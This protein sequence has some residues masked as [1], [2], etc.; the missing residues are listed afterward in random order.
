MLKT[1]RFNV[2]L[3]TC[4]QRMKFGMIACLITSLMLGSCACLANAREIAGLW[5]QAPMDWAYQGQTDLAAAGFDPVAKVALI[6]GHFWQQ[7][8]FEINTGGRYV[9]DFKNTSVIG[10]FRHIILDARMHPVAELQGGIESDEPNPFFLRHG[11]EIDFPAGHYRL[12][13]ELKSPFFLAYPQPYLDTLAH[14]RQAIKPWNALTL[15]CL[16]LF[17]GLLVYYLT[18]AIVRRRMSDAMYSIFILGNLLFNG[19]ALLV[20]PE[21]FGMHW[22]YLVSFPILFSNAAYVLF[23]MSLLKIRRDAY[24]RLHGA[25]VGLLVLMGSL[26]GLA[27]IRPHW[28]LEIDRYGVGLFLIYGLIIGILRSWQGSVTA[29]LY[30][31]AIVTFF[32]LGITTISAQSLSSYTLYIEHMGLFSVSVEIMLLALVITHQ[33][34]QLYHQKERAIERMEQSNRAARIDAM[35]GLPNRVALSEALDRMPSHGS[36]TFVDIDGLK[37][38]NDHFGHR[39]GDE[40]LCAFAKHLNERLGPR[41]RAHRLGGDEFAITCEQGDMSWVEGRLMQAVADMRSDGFEFADASAGSAYVHEAQDK[42]KLQHLADCRMYENKRSRRQCHDENAI[43][44][45]AA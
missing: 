29:R 6:G 24:P 14:Y 4:A 44:T 39:R 30:L 10:H 8:D 37:Y 9:L 3:N 21:L 27:M 15:L 23:V 38:Y 13:T 32:V 33:F 35:T 16:G 42:Q 5:Y 19:S 31:C 2:S 12:L 1:G 17:L 11:R 7:A 40:L 22:I 41:A 25:G 36:L 26:I 18:L 43:S 20:F 45:P 28:S 34:T